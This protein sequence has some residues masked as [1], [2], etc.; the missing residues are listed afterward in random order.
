MDPNS[1]RIGLRQSDTT[2][3]LSF[4]MESNFLSDPKKYVYV[5]LVLNEI[6]PTLPFCIVIVICYGSLSP[7]KEIQ[8]F[9]NRICLILCNF[10]MH[11]YKLKCIY[12][13]KF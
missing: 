2:G 10:Y 6:I 12:I 3:S 13:I 7:W 1:E 4:T 8:S 5:Q 9:Y 11:F